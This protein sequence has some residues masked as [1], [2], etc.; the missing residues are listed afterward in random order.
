MPLLQG[1]TVSSLVCYDLILKCY[2]LYIVY[3]FSSWFGGIAS[4]D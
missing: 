3:L 4:A 2:A 1:N